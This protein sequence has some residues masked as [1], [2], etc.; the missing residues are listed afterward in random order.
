[1]NLGIEEKTAV[2]VGAGGLGGAVA[3]ALAHEGAQVAAMG[4][5]L[6]AVERTAEAISADGYE[7]FAV[8]FDLADP[9]SFEPALDAVRAR[10]GEVDILFNNSGGP[11]PT[12]AFGQSAELCAGRFTSMVLG[13]IRLTDRPRLRCV[14]GAGGES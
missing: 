13:V 11:P 10:F 4:R 3:R 6:E 5:S 2:V 9:A 1:V 8:S 14:S 7:G 12:T